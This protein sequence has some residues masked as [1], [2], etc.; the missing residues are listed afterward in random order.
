MSDRVEVR[1][2]KAGG[3]VAAKLLLAIF[4]MALLALSL[5]RVF[6]RVE[7]GYAGVIVDPLTGYISE[8]PILGPRIGFKAPWRT[9]KSVY[10]ATDAVHMWTEF[11]VPERGWGKG[12]GD[13]PAIEALTKDGLQAWVDL[14]VRWHIDPDYAP[15]LVRAYPE[16]D[17]E[18]K[19]IVPEIRKVARDVVSQYEAATIAETR[20]EIG[21]EILQ[22]LRESLNSDPAVGSA[23][24]IDEVY[25]RNIRLPQKFMEAIQ[26]KLA[27]QQRMI[28]AQYERNRT[29]ILANASAQAKV[30]EAQGE[31]QARIIQAQALADAIDKIAAVGGNREAVAQL[32][33]LIQ[34]LAQLQANG[35]RFIVILSPQGGQLPLL[36]PVGE[37]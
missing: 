18:D 25:V 22:R 20:Q 28:A 4:I 2:P 11:E 34:N 16:L 14:T 31:A 10:V 37:G 32:Y 36:Y 27:A 26:E 12:V 17:Y 15:A 29:L 7:L 33:V 24:I 8:K 5:G 1:V 23:F 6:F 30:L 3:G 35:T 21:H 19:L 13:Y 9:V